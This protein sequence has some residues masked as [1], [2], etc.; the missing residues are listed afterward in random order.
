MW[1]SAFG[2][3]NFADNSGFAATRMSQSF[4]CPSRPCGPPASGRC[5]RPPSSL[6][7]RS[8][9]AA[10]RCRE[11]SC[12]IYA[13]P[14]SRIAVPEIKTPSNVEIGNR[15]LMN[16]R[17]RSLRRRRQPIAPKLERPLTCFGQARLPRSAAPQSC[18][19]RKVERRDSPNLCPARICR[20][21]TGRL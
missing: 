17:R 19:L 9:L 21:R 5:E 18:R 13:Y 7:F 16:G 4:L 1:K 10:C 3:L 15:R 2:M 14:Q 8:F 11:M 12:G 6:V 20:H